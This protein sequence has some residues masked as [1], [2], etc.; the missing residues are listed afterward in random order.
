MDP[1]RA[2]KEMNEAL[3]MASSGTPF[4]DPI[5]AIDAAGLEIKEDIDADSTF[6]GGMKS[7]MKATNKILEMFPDIAGQRQKELQDMQT[8]LLFYCETGFGRS[9]ELR[10]GM[11]E[12]SKV[13]NDIQNMLISL[14]KKHSI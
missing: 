3:A 13:Q 14:V 6:I 10:E 11:E 5:A 12:R 7:S 4:M 2:T 8:K 1:E 9:E